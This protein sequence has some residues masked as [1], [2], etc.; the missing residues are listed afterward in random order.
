MKMHLYILIGTVA[1]FI[2]L[3][4]ILIE[5]DN[6]NLKYKI[7]STGQNKIDKIDLLS[8]VKQSKISYIINS[9]PTQQISWSLLIWWVKTFRLGFFK[10]N[11][12]KAKNNYL[13]VHG[14]TVS[15]LM[16]ALLGKILGFKVL[17]VESGLRSFNFR[18][19]FPE[20]INRVLVSK[21]A[22][23]HFAPNKWAINN[24][25]KE[26]GIKIDT[27]NN[28]LI[29][30]LSIALNRG[31]NTLN[32]LPKKYFV[33]VLHRQENLIDTKFVKEIIQ[34]IVEQSNTIK[35]VFILHGNTVH[36]LK[37]QSLYKSITN[38]KNIFLLERVPYFKF[39]KI[40]KKAKFLVTDGGS[41]QEEA[42]YM[43]LPTFL[44]RECTERIEGINSNVLLGGK[45]MIALKKFFKNYNKF[46]KSPIK[47]V[48][49]PSKIIVDY[50]DS[51]K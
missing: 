16:G 26:R 11:K 7:I 27:K 41:N 1:E 23:V 8:E 36:S 39:M 19:P 34:N 6:R 18:S 2:K 38:N 15:T 24:L 51:N 37:N 20:E 3:L 49:S 5:L 45:N 43:G 21:L 42:F 35:C 44:I 48:N 46:K 28:T 17:H 22:D 30:S 4:P 10:L 33:F 12:L 29:E 14:D 50:L 9:Q 25:K 40:L 31:E 13:I 47:N 32:I